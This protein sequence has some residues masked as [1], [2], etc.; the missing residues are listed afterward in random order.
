MAEKT[1]RGGCLCGAIR[2]S[3]EGAPHN[4]DA[5]VCVTLASLDEPA[6]IAPVLHMRTGSRV[7]WLKIDD[8]LPRHE[9]QA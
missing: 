4:D 6:E 7:P 5:Y 9:G 2:Y 1:Y 3:A 8:D